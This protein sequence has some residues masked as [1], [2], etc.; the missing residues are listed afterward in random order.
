MR[1]LI[2][3]TIFVFCC[4]AISCGIGGHYIQAT[5]SMSPNI[6]IGDHFTTFEIKSNNLNP[7]ERFDIVVYKPQPN[8]ANLEGEKDTRLVHRVIGLPGE[9]IEI[10]KGAIYINGNLLDEPFKKNVG[11]IDFPATSIPENQY[12]LLGDNR[13]NSLDSRYWNKPTITREEIYGKVSNVIRK[14]DY[15][16][17]KR[18]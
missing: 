16:K 17:G 10:K 18:W 14:E 11:G 4:L 6:E 5:N 13:P 8:K 3:C 7:I 15:D 2:V 1:A 9:K 12:F